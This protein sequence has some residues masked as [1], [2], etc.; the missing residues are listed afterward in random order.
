MKFHNLNKDEA[1]KY[2]ARGAKKYADAMKVCIEGEYVTIQD[3]ATRTGVS[4]DT[5]RLRLHRVRKRHPAVTWAL[6]GAKE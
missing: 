4:R 6:L 2:G 1:A 3:I 5:A